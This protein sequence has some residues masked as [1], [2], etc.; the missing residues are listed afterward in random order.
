MKKKGKKWKKKYKHETCYYKSIQTER[1]TTSYL[2]I[3]ILYRSLND[4]L[5]RRISQ[6]QQI[7]GRS[8]LRSLAHWSQMII[9]S[10]RSAT[11]CWSWR[12]PKLNLHVPLRPDAMQQLIQKLTPSHLNTLL[13]RKCQHIQTHVGSKYR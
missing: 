9:R 1:R 6:H 2:T 11:G 5:E 13:Y 8:P 12:E 3:N 4:D 7:Y 10:S